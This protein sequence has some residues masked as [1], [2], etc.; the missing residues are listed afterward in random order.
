[1]AVGDLLGQVLGQVADALLGVLGPGQ[2]ALGVELRAEPSHMPGLI[3][4]AD[5][6]QRVLPGLED[7]AGGRVEVAA[8]IVIPDG[9]LVTGEPDG[10]RRGPP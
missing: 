1:M 3:V 2:H 10:I 4:R 6:I 9:Q 5:R 8:G 7:F